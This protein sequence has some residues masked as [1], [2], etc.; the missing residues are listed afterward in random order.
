M[1]QYIAPPDSGDDAS[2]CDICRQPRS[3]CVLLDISAELQP[4][5]TG[6]PRTLYICAGC[7][8][9]HANGAAGR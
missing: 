4:E 8:N 9:P 1:T 3:Y 6:Y 2:I 7:M 5:D